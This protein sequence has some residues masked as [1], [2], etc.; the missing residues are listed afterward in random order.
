M[1]LDALS[2]PV[3]CPHLV[4]EIASLSDQ[5]SLMYEGK[6][7]SVPYNCVP[8][9]IQQHAYTHLCIIQCCNAVS[10]THLDVYKRQP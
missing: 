10:Y 6:V 8:D 2:Q 7:I 9:T 4:F 1:M 3:K 5:Y